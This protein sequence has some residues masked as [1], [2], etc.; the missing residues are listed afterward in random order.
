M[1]EHSKKEGTIMSGKIALSQYV[2]SFKIGIG[3]HS[4]KIK[5][6]SN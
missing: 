2:L 1:Y 4:Q 5:H 6:D 3:L